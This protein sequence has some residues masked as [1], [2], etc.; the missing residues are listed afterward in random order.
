MT[1]IS[2]IIPTLNEA[3]ALPVLIT[4]L[5]AQGFDEIII[6]DASTCD[7]TAAAATRCRALCLPNLPKG[8]GAQMQAGAA[9]AT[10][11]VVFFLHADSYLPTGAHEA[12]R[13]TMLD[14]K[15]IGGSFSLA[16]DK[17]DWRL[18][19]YAWCSRINL[20]ITTYGDQGL[21]MARATFEQIGGFKPMPLLEDLD[22]QQRLRPLGRFVKLKAPITTSARRFVRRG[23]V[24]QQV[25]NVAIVLAYRLGVS[26]DTLA[27][28]YYGNRPS[29]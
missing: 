21:F 24:R 4:Q 22:I 23:I 28:W 12:I 11:D 3:A 13:A 5:Q 29:L 16:F 18:A 15:A 26:P 8:R 14:P 10:G 9:I 6:A 25:L 19:F 27:R 2:V 20:P 17:A 1:S 7:E